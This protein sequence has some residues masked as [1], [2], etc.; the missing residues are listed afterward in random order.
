[1]QDSYR[2]ANRHQCFALAYHAIGDPNSAKNELQLA[3]AAN[4][5]A[6]GRDFSC[7]RYLEVSRGDMRKDL[8][9]LE[10]YVNGEG[11]EP[12]VLFSKDDDPQLFRQ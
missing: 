5:A 2:S 11:R 3:K 8:V 12:V 1:M 7:W 6:R 10:R 4:E 9:A